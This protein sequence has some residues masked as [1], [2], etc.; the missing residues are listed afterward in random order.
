MEPARGNSPPNEYPDIVGYAPD[1]PFWLAN[2][3]PPSP[4]AANL[5]ELSLIPLL[6][7][8]ILGILP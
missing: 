3:R 5:P 1:Q 8:T 4:L 2:F 7:R 6:A